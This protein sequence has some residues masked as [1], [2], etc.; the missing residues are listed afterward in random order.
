MSSLRGF[1]AVECEQAGFL[2]VYQETCGG[3]FQKGFLMLQLLTIAGD[4]KIML[5]G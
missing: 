4:L 3:D 1:F 5:Q 2:R